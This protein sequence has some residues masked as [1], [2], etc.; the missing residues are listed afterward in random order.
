M[1]CRAVCPANEG[2]ETFRKVGKVGC[3]G[4]NYVARSAPLMRG[5]K[6][7][8]SLG[9][10]KSTG[11]EGRAVCPANEGIETQGSKLDDHR[12]KIVARSAP[13]MRGLKPLG[14]GR[15][16][17][18]ALSVARSAPLMRGLKHQ[19]WGSATTAL[20]LVSRGLPR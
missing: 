15:D 10:N 18:S 6:L 1:I 16:R 11:R 5:L 4:Q 13:L 3:P 2:I 8:A 14:R 20:F 17:G 9:R 19:V 12:A 7:V